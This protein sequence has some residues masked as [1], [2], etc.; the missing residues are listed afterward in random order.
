[1]PQ[2]TVEGEKLPDE[3][4]NTGTANQQTGSSA[5]A[6]RVKPQAFCVILPTGGGKPF[7]ITGNTPADFIPVLKDSSLA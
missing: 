6:G 3:N 2:L 4:N 5:E 1:M 7:K